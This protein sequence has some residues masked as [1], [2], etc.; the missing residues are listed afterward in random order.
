MLGV[1]HGNG[2]PASNGLQVNVLIHVDDD[3]GGR[4]VLELF[5]EVITLQPSDVVSNSVALLMAK[6]SVTALKHNHVMNEFGRKQC[7]QK[8][9]TSHQNTA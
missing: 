8:I 2:V 7:K 5:F 3:I 1:L 4:S 9:L 6:F